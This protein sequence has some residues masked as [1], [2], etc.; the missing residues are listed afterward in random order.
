M[1]PSGLKAN[2]PVH[3]WAV[4]GLLQEAHAF[5]GAPA[6]LGTSLHVRCCIDA[7]FGV[8]IASH[9][10]MAWL[11]RRPCSTR[12]RARCSSSTT[13]SP[14]TPSAACAPPAGAALLTLPLRLPTC[15]TMRRTMGAAAEQG[16]CVSLLCDPEPGCTV[17]AAA[18]AS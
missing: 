1:L 11:V 14:R 18:A 12:C 7:A 4:G 2:A 16:P 3:T 13:P 8:C 6:C 5:L 10:N 15:A 9:L 17:R